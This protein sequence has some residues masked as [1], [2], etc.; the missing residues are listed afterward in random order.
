M[1]TG[2]KAEQPAG[3]L[4]IAYEGTYG[5]TTWAVVQWMMFAGSGDPS[6][7]DVNTLTQDLHTAFGDLV[8][9]TIF[10]DQ[11][12]L[13]HTKVRYRP[14][15][16]TGA[17]RSTYVADVAGQGN[18]PYESG[19][20]CFLINWNTTDPRRGGKARSYI[21]GVQTTDVEQEGYVKGSAVTT[22]NGYIATYLAALQAISVGIF[23]AGEL[24]E[25]SF[26]NGNAYRATPE[27]YVIQSGFVNPVVGS[28][29]RRVDR[30]R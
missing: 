16:G 4:R 25:M 17:Y 23:T 6:I 11:L 14:I 28:Q 20:V 21:P 3:S 18:N 12:H 5:A 9:H 13:T 27:S 26:V 10:A 24:V 15:G 7:A 1:P 19:Q 29:R 22:L 2:T 30:L 8:H